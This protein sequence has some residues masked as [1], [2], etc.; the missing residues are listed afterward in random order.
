M[1]IEAASP[2]KID[3]GFSGLSCIKLLIMV[4]STCYDKIHW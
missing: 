3:R 4:D 2:V 1:M